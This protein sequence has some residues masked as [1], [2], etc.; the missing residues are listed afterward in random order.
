MKVALVRVIRINWR[1]QKLYPL[2]IRKEAVV[3][4]VVNQSIDADKM[5]SSSDAD[6]LL[7][8]SIPDEAK[9]TPLEAVPNMIRHRR[10]PA[11]EARKRM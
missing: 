5:M 6:N 9:K 1:I 8:V 7:V 3:K 10:V 11:E 4:S 2:E